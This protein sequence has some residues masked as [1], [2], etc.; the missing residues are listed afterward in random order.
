MN[1]ILNKTL[2]LESGLRNIR[3]LSNRYKKAKIY[4][5]QD[6]D[7]VTTALAMKN[8]LENN[9][10]PNIFVYKNLDSYYFHNCIISLLLKL[11]RHTWH[12]WLDSNQHNSNYG[13]KR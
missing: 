12:G 8:Y 6:L 4:F 1:L 10:R 11:M 13:T 9:F 3:E 5:H 2:L 7:G